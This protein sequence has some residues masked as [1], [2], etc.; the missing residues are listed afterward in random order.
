MNECLFDYFLAYNGRFA[1][2]EWENELDF[3]A[4]SVKITHYTLQERKKKES[5]LFLNSL[6]DDLGAATLF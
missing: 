1:L 2:H 5:F 4:E 6:A 3:Y